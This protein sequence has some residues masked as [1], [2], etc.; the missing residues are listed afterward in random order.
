MLWEDTFYEDGQSVA[1]RIIQTI[2]SVSAPKVASLAVEAREKFKLRHVPL[3]IV[4]EMAR[5]GTTHKYLVA[6]TLG[7]VIQR[8]DELAEF[9]A[10]YWKGEKTRKKSPLSAQVKKGLAA[11]FQKFNEYQLSKYDRDG[12]IKLR[13]VLFLCHA[14]PKD[15]EQEALWKRLI[16]KTLVT[17]DTWEVEISKN[18]SNKDSWERLL[19]EN[20]LGGLALLRNLRN[21][22]EAG[23][24]PE[25]VH[26]AFLRMKVE[27]ILPFRFIAA[28]KYAPQW[29]AWIE[30]AMLKC[31][32]GMEKLPGKT[33]LIVDGSGSMFGTKVSDRSEIDR[34][35]AA[36]ALA[37]LARE[38]CERCEVLVFSNDTFL[39]PA[40]RG[41]ALRDALYK[42]A[43]QGGTN[44]QHAVAAAAG[45]GYD[46]V[47]ILTD[48]QSHQSISQPLPGAK[49]YV[50]NVATYQN[51]IGYGPWTHIDGWSE[52]VLA[53]IQESEKV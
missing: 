34:F 32:D 14:K 29:E 9:L 1:D 35:E 41:F 30:E 23:V 46:R 52:A 40:R 13:D 37:I 6:D 24:D 17:P 7:R 11:A 16:N 53:Y 43:Q 26:D 15:D 21:M 51:G 18:K 2:S 49:G 20:K 38:L 8:P 25:L 33:V 4:R 39:V 36:S 42:G 48:E 22:S 3:L 27:R 45:L 50:I 19:C 10:I 28:A 47:I 31:T 12:S 5:L 44:T